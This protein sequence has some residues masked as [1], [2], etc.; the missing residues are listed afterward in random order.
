MT[1]YKSFFKK[2]PVGREIFYDTFL[3]SPSGNVFLDAYHRRRNQETAQFFGFPFLP[4]MSVESFQ[5]RKPLLR[6]VR[7]SFFRNTAGTPDYE[8]RIRPFSLQNLCPKRPWRALW[9]T[10]DPEGES[11]LRRHKTRF[12]VDIEIARERA[13]VN[14]FDEALLEAPDG[15]AA[16]FSIGNLFLVEKNRL[17]T[18]PLDKGILPGVMRQ[19][20][21]EHNTPEIVEETVTLDR[22]LAGDGLIL[23]NGLRILVFIDG[24]TVD[25]TEYSLRQSPQGLS[26]MTNW[27]DRMSTWME[28]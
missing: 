26:L 14:S 10:P 23:S 3:L 11:F 12:N 19:A 24:L 4:E 27:K 2:C 6:R 21:M 20:L 22:I 17:I 7:V 1:A 13:V 28:L 16:E 25:N 15:S 5:A 8:V 18:P 9:V